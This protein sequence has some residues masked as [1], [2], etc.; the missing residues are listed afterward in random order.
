MPED[1]TLGRRSHAQNHGITFGQFDQVGVVELPTRQ[2]SHRVDRCSLT[3]GSLAHGLHV[4][5]GNGLLERLR[6]PL[7]DRILHAEKVL[8]SEEHTSELQSLAYLVCRLLLEKKK[9]APTRQRY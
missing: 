7:N 4:F 9:Q 2:F 5:K 6:V 8:R 3:K 1:A